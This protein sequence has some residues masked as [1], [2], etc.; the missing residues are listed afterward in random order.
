M[1]LNKILNRRFAVLPV[2]SILTKKSAVE[3]LGERISALL[4]S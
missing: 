4:F 1:T 2:Q 3:P